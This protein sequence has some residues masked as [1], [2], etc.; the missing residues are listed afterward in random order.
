M[1]KSILRFMVYSNLFIGLCALALAFE[2]FVLL[3]IPVSN[4]WFLLL[5]FLC[6]IFI[7]SL[8]YYI[9][10]LS[11]KNDSRLTWCRNNRA[12]LL[13]I[14]FSSFFFSIGGVVYHYR[15][16]FFSGNQ[17]S[18]RNLIWF[19]LIPVL[20]LAYSYPVIPWKNKS[21]RQVGWLK[22]ASLA[23]TWSFTTVIL[24]V[25][26][27]EQTVHMNSTPV[28]IIV[29]F[30][31]RFLFIASVGFLFNIKDYQEDKED[32]IATAAVLLGPHRSLLV[33]KWLSFSS[34]ILSGVLV[35][36][37][38]DL[39]SP[40]YYAAVM[41]PAILLFLSFHSFSFSTEEAPFVIRYDGLMI[42][43]ALLLIFAVAISS[44]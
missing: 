44:T 26:M 23:F 34:N 39:Y 40:A 12:L 33:G 32:N 35:I 17:F 18:Y 14:L 6:T 16:I 10:S 8:H 43:K 11:E 3:D 4:N 27:P 28:H 22:M 1:G 37:F 21:L 31:N 38:F 36:Y 30:L 9:K 42:I 25:L 15:S 24:P 20:A 7:Y 19:A 29:L 13:A 41:L 2:T 5:V